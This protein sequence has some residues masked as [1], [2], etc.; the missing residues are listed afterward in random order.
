MVEGFEME[1]CVLTE[2]GRVLSQVDGHV[3]DVSCEDAH[4]FSLL[5][6]ELVM[7]SAEDAFCGFGLIILHEMGGEVESSEGGSIVELGKPTT[8]ISETPGPEDLDITQRS[9]ENLHPR[10]IDDSD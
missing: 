4:E 6:F 1:P 8:V 7:E 2:G 10:M 9:I 5:F 3:V